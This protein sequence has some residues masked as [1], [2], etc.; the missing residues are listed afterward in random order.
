MTDLMNDWKRQRFIVLPRELVEGSPYGITVLMSDYNYWADHV[1]ECIEWCGQY[2]CEI[3]GMTIEIP[4]D[5]T[6]TLFSLR[7]SG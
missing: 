6:L 4:N 5:E 2:G 7:W 1:G 3:K